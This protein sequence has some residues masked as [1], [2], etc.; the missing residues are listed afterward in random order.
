MRGRKPE[1]SLDCDALTAEALLVELCP[2]RYAEEVTPDN[3]RI[4]H[5]VLVFEGK[6]VRVR[7]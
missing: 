3:Y 1:L 5:S 6:G 2:H 7:G 4:H